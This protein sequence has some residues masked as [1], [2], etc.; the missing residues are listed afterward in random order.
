MRRTTP[1]LLGI[2]A[3]TALVPLSAAPAAAGSYGAYGAYGAYGSAGAYGSD[4]QDDEPPAWRAATYEGDTE[5]DPSGPT[6]S[7]HNGQPATVDEFPAIIAGLRAGG[8]RPQGQTCTGSVI[9]PR[10]ILIAAHCADSSGEKSFLYGLDDLNDAGGTRVAVV[11][12]KKHPKYVNFDQGYDV[13]VVTVAADIP[14]RGGKY[15]TVATSADAGLEKPG[16]SGLGFGYGRKE[17]DDSSR[18]VTLDKATLPIV[19]GDRVCTGVGAGFKSATMVCAGYADGRTTILPGDSG[20]PLIVDGKVIGVASWSRSDFKWYSVYGRLTNEM[21][22]WVKAQI[23]DTP[24]QAD[25]KIAASPSTVKVAPGKYISTTVTSTAGQTGAENIRLT[26]SGL[27]T[28]VTATF[29]PDSIT[30]GATAKLTLDAA[31]TAPAGNHTI[32]VTGTNAAGKASTTTIT[33]TVEGSTSGE[34]KVTATPSS[35]TVRQ[36]QLAQTAVTAT[37]G[38]GNLT[39][40]ASGAPAGTQVFYNPATIAQGGTSNVWFFTNFQTAPG[41]YPI[42]ITARSS[43]GKTGT[44]TY[45]L[46]ITR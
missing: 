28:G 37:G 45:T 12:Y 3:L 41:T 2:A 15:A 22:D 32:T 27:P 30:T 44:T 11:D 36:G 13:A 7:F 33:L 39:I 9:A 34:V 19:D 31:T 18:D 29:Q 20:G 35:G 5:P 23:V 17:F 6:T 40:S 46:T 1:L 10:K 4:M 43:D 25:F 42:K 14:V 16:G 26:A 38:T 21:G 24:P 8:T